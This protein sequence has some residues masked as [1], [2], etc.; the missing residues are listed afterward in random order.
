MRGRLC[1][2]LP[3]ATPGDNGGFP[4]AGRAGGLPR[5]PAGGSV[6]FAEESSPPAGP[7]RSPG[8]E[9]P[10]PHVPTAAFALGGF[11]L[12]A[13]AV[14]VGAGADV[15]PERNGFQIEFSK[16]RLRFIPHTRSPPSALRAVCADGGTRLIFFQA[17][18]ARSLQRGSGESPAVLQRGFGDIQDS[19]RALGQT[20]KS[21]VCWWE[22][23]FARQLRPSR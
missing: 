22:G 7:S 14:A 20:W 11:I 13:A 19:G 1:P 17:R 23:G 3:S 15:E 21:P 6:P 8:A 12:P 18:L 4:G 10:S 2:P 9:P 16:S 5:G